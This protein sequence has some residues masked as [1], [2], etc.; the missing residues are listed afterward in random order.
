MCYYIE[1]YYVLLHIYYYVL[2]QHYY[3]II[4]NGKSCNNDPISVSY[5]SYA[6]K[7]H[8]LL[9]Y[10]YVIITP[11]SITTHYYLFQSPEKADDTLTYGFPL[12]M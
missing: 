4:T 12:S 10:Y 1:F 11:G 9:P 8:L 3:I 6:K 2:L 5:G 7:K